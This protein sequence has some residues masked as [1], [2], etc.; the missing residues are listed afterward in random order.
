M[1]NT[2]VKGVNY[3]HYAQYKLMVNNCFGN[4][5]TVRNSVNGTEC[6]CGT[7]FIRLT[8]RSSANGTEFW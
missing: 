6:G 7:Y 4:Q 3:V 5:L 1:S 2:C 8:V